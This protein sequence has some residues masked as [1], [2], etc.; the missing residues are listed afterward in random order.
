MTTE[1]F[2]NAVRLVH[3]AIAYRNCAMVQPPVLSH[4]S[5]S[6][7]PPPG[8]GG[9]TGT[10]FRGR[11]EVPAAGRRCGRKENEKKQRKTPLRC[12]EHS[13][14]LPAEPSLG[15]ARCRGRAKFVRRDH[16][17]IT[18][19]GSLTNMRGLEMIDP[20]RTAR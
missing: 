1:C 14:T 11:G 6:G 8:A 3:G 15:R 7:G 16:A 4:A 5:A 2:G 17:G 10:A 18:N 19:G 20:W 13:R 9:V 12:L